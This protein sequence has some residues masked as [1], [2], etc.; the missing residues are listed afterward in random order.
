MKKILTLFTEWGKEA[1]NLSPLRTLLKCWMKCVLRG[2]WSVGLDFFFPLI[3]SA[4]ALCHTSLARSQ[5]WV[6][7][8]VVC[9]L[10]P[11]S[12][13]ML[14]FLIAAFCS[15]LSWCELGWYFELKKSVEIYSW[16]NVGESS[17]FC[18]HCYF[19]PCSLYTIPVLVFTSP[20]LVLKDGQE[21]SQEEN[22]VADF[23]NMV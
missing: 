4:G 20:G 9:V 3:S 15:T 6:W 5:M 10:T 13:T 2:A 17:C 11:T 21:A 23:K 16:K 1:Q 18:H 7:H 22:V 19:W 12:A 8:V 14:R